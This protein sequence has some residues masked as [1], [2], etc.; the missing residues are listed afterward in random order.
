[1]RVEEVPE[2]IVVDASLGL[3]WVLIEEH[4]DRAVALGPGRE[5]LTSAL[6]WAESGNAIATRVR[7]GE[8]DGTRAERTFRDLQSVPLRTRPLDGSSVIAALAIARDLVHPIYD[9]CYLA[10]AIEEN[11]VVV[12][13]DRRFRAAVAQHP[14][15]ADRV[16]LLR[17]IVLH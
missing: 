11:L 4:S 2:R 7:R 6:F 13:A 1:M 10:L 9:C 3:K 5:L 15:L 17:D 12:T 8:L 16:L 14:S